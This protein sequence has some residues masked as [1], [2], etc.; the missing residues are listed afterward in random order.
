MYDMRSKS[1]ATGSVRKS[2]V[3][4][5]KLLEAA[6]RAAPRLR[7]NFNRLVRTALEEFIRRREEEEFSEAMARMARDP[8]MRAESRAIEAEFRHTEMDGLPS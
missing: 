8:A 6:S 5:G 2:V 4:S 3:L 7:G 1:R